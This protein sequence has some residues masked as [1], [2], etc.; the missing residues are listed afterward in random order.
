MKRDG[1]YI[2]TAPN[3]SVSEET[4]M[5]LL[6]YLSNDMDAVQ[7]T[8]SVVLSSEQKQLKRFRRCWTERWGYPH[9]A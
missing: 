9:C 6:R 1:F 3:Y 8:G 7:P 4:A 5:D 2:I